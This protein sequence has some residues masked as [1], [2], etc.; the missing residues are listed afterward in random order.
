MSKE[1]GKRRG[2]GERKRERRR[3]E[4]RERR[5]EE[6]RERDKLRGE[7]RGIIKKGWMSQVDEYR[8]FP[9]HDRKPVKGFKHGNDTFRL[10]LCE[11]SSARVTTLLWSST[12]FWWYSI[13]LHA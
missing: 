8:L 7:N 10:F 1:G 13:W 11:A 3:E 5:R 4:G 12:V 2:R 9:D 6:G